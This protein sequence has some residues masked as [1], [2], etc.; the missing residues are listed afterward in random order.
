[1]DEAIKE[2]REFKGTKEEIL[3]N[4]VQKIRQTT[5]GRCLAN[6][7]QLRMMQSQLETSH[8]SVA[9]LQDHLEGQMQLQAAKPQSQV[10]SK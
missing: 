7:R 6:L 1:M 8:L 5:P 10:K 9:E 3:Q 2:L 4:A